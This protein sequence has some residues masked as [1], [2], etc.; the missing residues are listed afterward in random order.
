[1]AAF[2]RHADDPFN[3][4]EMALAYWVMAITIV[5]TGPGFFSLDHFICKRFKKKS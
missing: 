5:L 3:V 2:I 1:V 4:K